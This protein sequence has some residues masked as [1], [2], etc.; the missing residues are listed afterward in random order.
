MAQLLQMEIPT[1]NLWVAG[2]VESKTLPTRLQEP[3]KGCNFINA[4]CD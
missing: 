4:I 1:H 3:K 2:E